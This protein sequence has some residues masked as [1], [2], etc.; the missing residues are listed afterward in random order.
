MERVDF[1]TLLVGTNST[2][3]LEQAAQHFLKHTDGSY[4]PPI[5]LLVVQ[6]KW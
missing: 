3:T 4:F 2:A 6:E 1:P 5:P